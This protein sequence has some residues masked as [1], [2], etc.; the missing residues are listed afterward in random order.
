M[1]IYQEFHLKQYYHEITFHAYDIENIKRI[2]PYDL[3][4]IYVPECWKRDWDEGC[5]K[6]VVKELCCC[7]PV[8]HNQ[9][10]LLDG[11]YVGDKYGF[12]ND[13]SYFASLQTGIRVPVNKEVYE[14]W[15][16][17][18]TNEGWTSDDKVYELSDKI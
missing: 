2:T 14:E 16:K 15:R 13:D 7:C 10:L 1:K 9:E 5:Y 3:S 6:R 12:L 8:G 18:W 17:G 4:K 11:W